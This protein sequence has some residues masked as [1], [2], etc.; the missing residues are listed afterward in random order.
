MKNLLV[1]LIAIASLGPI[2]AL[3]AADLRAA[4]PWVRGTVPG[5]TASGGYVDLTS[6]SGATLVGASSSVAG[7]AEVHEMKTENGVMKMR[8]LDVLPIPAGQT[9][10]LAPGGYH[11]ML[12][13]LKQMLV[14]GKSVPVTLKVRDAKGKTETLE[15][16]FEV[17]DPSGAPAGGSTQ[18]HAG[19]HHH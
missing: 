17:R 11:L 10:S 15:V 7:L 5:Q 8:R 2:T 18:D 14:P 6:K 3:R 19:H 9:V 4:S 16:N 13:D 12:M 1:S